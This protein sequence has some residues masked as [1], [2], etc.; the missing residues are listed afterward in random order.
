M[1]TN[2]NHDY[3]DEDRYMTDVVDPTNRYRS[4]E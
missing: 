4:D 3:Y 1:T 2:D